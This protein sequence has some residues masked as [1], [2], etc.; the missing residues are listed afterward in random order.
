MSVLQLVSNAPVQLTNPFDSRLSHRFLNTVNCSSEDI[1]KITPSSL[2]GFGILQQ[3]QQ[4]KKFPIRL[5]QMQKMELP[6][7][8]DIH[9]TY[10]CLD[11][12]PDKWADISIG[13]RSH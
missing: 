13:E 3:R 11:N 6:V 7:R 10:L 2:W 4:D 1:A 9:C 5:V 12:S 8:A